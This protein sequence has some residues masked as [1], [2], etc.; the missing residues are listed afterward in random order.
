ML[1]QEHTC[2]CHN[3]VGCY[4]RRI[5]E[6]EEMHL[7]LSHNRLRR[8]VELIAH[9]TPGISITKCPTSAYGREFSD[10]FYAA[11]KVKRDDDTDQ[12]SR[13]LNTT[14]A[15]RMRPSDRS[16]TTP[17]VRQVPFAPSNWDYVTS[18]TRFT[19]AR[20]I[21]SKAPHGR[22]L[23]WDE[24]NGRF[25]ATGKPAPDPTES[26]PSSKRMKV[27]SKTGKVLDDGLELEVAWSF[28]D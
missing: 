14:S 3:L 17:T 21:D 15:S 25:G 11:V 19:S 22:Q 28:A 4:V 24:N 10:E 6:N 8:W 2:K 27:V 5:N 18:P 16:A 20:S 9:N 1:Q 12:D 23:S 7:P 13:A 26:G